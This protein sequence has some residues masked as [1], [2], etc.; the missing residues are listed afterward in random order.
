M[1]KCFKLPVIQACTA[2]YGFFPGELR[3][4]NRVVSRVKNS[5]FTISKIVKRPGEIT[6]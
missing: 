1:V 3:W 5:I 6:K 4:E 2:L